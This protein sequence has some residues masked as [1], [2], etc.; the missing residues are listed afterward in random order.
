MKRAY[1]NSLDQD[2]MSQS[3][4]FAQKNSILIGDEVYIFFLP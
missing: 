3:A 2:Q 1:A 4:L